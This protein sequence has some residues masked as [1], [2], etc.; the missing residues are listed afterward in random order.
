MTAPG[1]SADWRIVPSLGITETWTDNVE[2]L[3]PGQERSELI[4]EIVPALSLSVNSRRLKANASGAWRQYLYNDSDTLRQP[5]NNTRQ[6]AANLEG[7]LAEDLMFIDASASSSQQSL[8]AF[9]PRAVDSPFSSL[10]RTQI[11]TWSVS[12]YLVHNFGR[13]ASALLRYTRDSVESDANDLF[14]NSTSDTL[15]LN[16]NSRNEARALGWNLSYLRQE[17]D[18]KLAGQSSVENLNGKLRYRLNSSFALTA[19]AGYDRYDYDAIGDKTAGASWSTGFAW[20]PSQRTSIEASIG[21][22]FYGSTGSLAASVRSRRTVWSINYGDTITNSRSQFTLPSAIDTVSMLDRLFSATISDP[23]QRQ[24][25]VAAYIQS[26]GLPPSLTNNVNYLSNRYVRQKLLQATAAFRW[27]RT[28]AILNLFGSERTALSSRENDSALLGNQL[29]SLND[30]V[31]QYGANA[32]WSYSLG[33]RSSLVANATYSHS[34]SLTT[35]IVD[36]QRLLRIGIN[37][38]IGRYLAGSLDLR[39]RNGT[40]YFATT[41]PGD[42][43]ENAIAAT[44]SMTL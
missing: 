14:G 24:L 40:S 7:I 36:N 19:S 9:G 3:P 31:R 21:R 2:L 15:S 23:V 25:A 6:Y 27:S 38:K 16:L 11:K 30:D 26:A 42:Y 37:R 13:T 17:Q 18:N 35:G 39:R 32:T 8:S 22:H 12:P 34:E 44:L 5:N 33:P 29:S 20:A 1:A 28:N 10:N 4:T 43:T 41:A